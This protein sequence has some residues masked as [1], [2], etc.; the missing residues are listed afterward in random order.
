MRHLN[1][2]FLFSLPLLALLATGCGGGTLIGNASQTVYFNNPGT[3][4]VGSQLALSAM[5]SSGLMVSFTS[6]T[7]SICTVS[8]TTATLVAAG[9]C[10]I[11]ASA[12]GNIT[13]APATQVAQSFTVNP[14]IAPNT[15][16]YI[17]GYVVAT[18]TSQS[19][20]V[21]DAAVWK[22]ASGSTTAT[23]TTLASPSSL[24]NSQANG[25]AVSGS[26]VYVAGTAFNSSYNDEDYAVLWVNGTAT[27]LA[28]PSGMAYSSA[29]AIAVSGSNV[30]VA[31]TAWN[32]NSSSYQ[33]EY[34]VLWVNGTATL[35]AP[36]S[37]M[38]YSLANAIT[39]SG[40]NVYVAGTAWVY[41]SDG[42]AVVWANGTATTLSSP[43]GLAGGYNATG[44][45]VSG[46]NV[47]VS[48]YTK[49]HSGYETAFSW[50]NSG[51][52]TT[53]PLL[54]GSIPENYFANG[55]TVLG[56][57]VYIVG[58]GL[59]GATGISGAA[60]WVNGTATSLPLPSNAIESADG[61]QANGI[62]FSGSDMYAVGRYSGEVSVDYGQS[63][64][65]AYWVNGA[66][67]ALL[68]M[69]SNTYES[70]ASAVAVA[71]Q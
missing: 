30:Y 1:R 11:D 47:Y 44:I 55:I 6:T 58:S 13:Y 66:P 71:T 54:P 57:D 62:A 52:A 42:S 17:A 28:P 12:G 8:G 63:E 50:L 56:G 65:A 40:S 26:D 3:Q 43:S 60:F 51:P 36:P 32:S 10:T 37:G 46:G 4:T 27:L 38:A 67:A 25:V 14:A 48:G 39:V 21:T 16:I 15:T 2:I 41:N 23:A 53:L 22:L 31:G 34:A 45:A 68:P 69:P 35:L 18:P 5:T 20:F 19:G 64:I 7:P 70:S 9:T 33:Y 49:P 61:T 59:N 29:N 24:I